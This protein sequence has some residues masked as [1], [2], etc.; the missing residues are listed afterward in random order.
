MHLLLFCDYV[1][2]VGIDLQG[3]EENRVRSMNL[4]S[5]FDSN[6]QAYGVVALSLWRRSGEGDSAFG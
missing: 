1:K 6:I 2:V 3:S 4:R 5:L